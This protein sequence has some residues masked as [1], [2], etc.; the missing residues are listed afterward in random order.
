ME[1]SQRAAISRCVCVLLFRRGHKTQ[2]ERERSQTQQENAEIEK[3]REW[4]RNYKPK[5]GSDADG[6]GCLLRAMSVSLYS[7]QSSSITT[8]ATL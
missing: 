5:R 8:P 6:G 1:T 2:R 7:Y 4:D 3:G